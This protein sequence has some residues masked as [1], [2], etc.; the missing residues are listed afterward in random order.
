VAARDAHARETVMSASGNS[1]RRAASALTVWILGIGPSAAAPI[2][3]SAD[4][5]IRIPSPTSCEVSMTLVVEGASAIDH[6]LESPAGVT[7]D[8]LRIVG[9][10]AT[11]EPQAI[12]STRS[13]VLTPGPGAYTLSYRVQQS[14]TRTHRCP[15]WLPAVPTAGVARAVTLRVDLPP[16]SDPGNTMPRFTWSGHAGTA[17]L[18]H[19]P[20]FVLVPY[21]A[22]GGPAAWDVSTVMDVAAVFMFVVA[23]ALWVWRRRSR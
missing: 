12:G 22:A 4:V 13:L 14:A 21:S 7:V 10:R 18:A 8:E 2:L 3:R 16:E 6:R 11:S 20:A 17:T 9:A 5:S 23:S 15:L 1:L 19:L